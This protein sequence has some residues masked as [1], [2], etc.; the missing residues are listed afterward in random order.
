[1]LIKNNLKFV[2]F[3]QFY[4]IF[5]ILHV[6][7]SLVS[8]THMFHDWYNIWRQNANDQ[9]VTRNNEMSVVASVIWQIYAFLVESTK[10]FF[11]C[12]KG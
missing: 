6:N 3:V 11:L 9:N 4:N 12:S 1:M 8:W 10:E 7:I 2:F 5:A